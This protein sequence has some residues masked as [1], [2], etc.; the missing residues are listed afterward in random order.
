MESV[1]AFEAKDEPSA[2]TI[3]VIEGD[4]LN[5]L[6]DFYR[7]VY[8]APTDAL[9]KQRKEAIVEFMKGFSQRELQYA[10]ADIAAFGL[11]STHST[12]EA[13]A[14]N[15]IISAI[16]VPQPSFSSDID[17]NA[18]DLR[19]FA[20]VALG[21]HLLTQGDRSTAALVISA[22]ATKPLPQERY[23]AEFISALLDAARTSAQAAAAAARERPDLEIAGLQGTDVPN[24]SKSV[25]AALDKFR[26]AIERNLRTD[27][28]ELQILWWVFGS[29]STS[30][31]SSFQDIDLPERVMA[32]AS[33]LAE[34]VILPPT[35]G[36]VQFLH[37]VLKDDRPLTLR[38]LMEPCDSS[39]LASVVRH[40]EAAAAVLSNHPALLPLTW[41]SCRRVDS[42]M[43]PGWEAEFEQKTH[44]S[45]ADERAASSWAIQVF[46]E[47][48]TARLL[49][50]SWDQVTE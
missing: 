36:S 2:Q 11:S 43:A 35:K 13:S 7:I 41:V 4:M 26:E 50:E 5:R 20:G 24:F 15:A 17:A 12:A 8:P 46:N 10:C 25:K 16:Q 37:A 47:S 34:L 32:S 45:V 31:G 29:H 42:G 39:L 19:V 38:R 49:A 18:L 44:I 22:L 3:K 48:V 33:E 21:E 23:L 14:A 27:Q 30:L 28:E 40:R 1:P 6:S 9:I